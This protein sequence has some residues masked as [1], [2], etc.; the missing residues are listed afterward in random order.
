MIRTRRSAERVANTR[1][2]PPSPPTVPMP[3]HKAP[4]DARR[5]S[6]LQAAFTVAT[7]ERLGG[8]TT[9]AVATEAGVSHGLVFFHFGRREDLLVALLDWL[10]ATTLHPRPGRLGP[11]S[12]AAERLYD[13]LH[14]DLA[15]LPANR[16]RVEMLFDFWVM[17][18]RHPGVQS[19]IRAALDAY[20]DAYRPFAEAVVAADPERFGSVTPDGLAAAVT[21]LV[22]GVALQV[23]MDPHGVDLHAVHAA[24]RALVPVST[25]DAASEG[26]AVT[27]ISHS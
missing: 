15:G 14:R 3:G 8:L 1:L 5:E 17:G 16:A 12:T 21:A 25:G 20:R 13:A 11:A 6:L 26:P 4:E 2:A 24:L 19:R 9:R 23:V 22:E 7:R 10:L 27:L 18:T